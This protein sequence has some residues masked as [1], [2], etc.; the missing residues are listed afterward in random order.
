[1]ALPAISAANRLS[2]P[3]IFGVTRLRIPAHPSS[4]NGYAS[5]VG[6]EREGH[7]HKPKK[8]NEISMCEGVRIFMS[9][10]YVA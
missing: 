4:S 3:A 6:F 10:T 7:F 8:V 1:M 2:S 5:S 9:F